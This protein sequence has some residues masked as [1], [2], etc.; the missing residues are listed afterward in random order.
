[1]NKPIAVIIGDIH[2]TP[3]TLEP[4]TQSFIMAQKE[5]LRLRVPLIVNGDTLDS[6]AIMRA[7][8]VNRLLELTSLKTDVRPVTYFNVGNHDMMNE[9]GEGHTLGFL[10]AHAYVIDTPQKLSGTDLWIIPYQNSYDKMREILHSISKGSTLIVHQG[11]E[12]ACMG[13]YVQDKTSLSKAA[14]AD[15]RVIASHY[16]KAQNI[17]CGRPRKGGVGLFSYIGNPYTLSFGEA[18]D[19]P[20][21]FSVLYDNGIL[22]NIPTNLRKHVIVSCSPSAVEDIAIW[23]ESKKDDL[24]WVKVKGPK[25]ELCSIDKSILK[26][27]KL[28]LIPTDSTEIKNIENKT[29]HEILDELID[30]SGETEQEK[31]Y[32]KKLWREIT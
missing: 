1:M 29:E 19:G 27:V 25:S 26:N 21:G 22:E 11:V 16:H 15:F 5:A 32:L 8:C 9:K 14:Y 30:N 13:H 24:Y 18:Y 17:K 10:R 7:E 20:K 4:A 12:S 28:D 23:L 2:F 31:V 3:S 6:K